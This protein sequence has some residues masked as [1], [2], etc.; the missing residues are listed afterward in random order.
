MPPIDPNTLP[1]LT[2]KQMSFE[3]A[4]KFGLSITTQSNDDGIITIRGLTR[5]G[6]FL[7]SHTTVSD[8]DRHFQRFA[9]PDFPI[10]IVAINDDATLNHG[11]TF[12][13]IH[14]EINDNSMLQLCSGFIDSMTSISYPA[15]QKQDRIPGRGHI[16]EVVGANPAAGAEVSVTVP[17]GAIWLIHAFTVTFVADANPANRRVNIL[18]T[19][20]NGQEVNTVTNINQV[21]GATKKYNVANYGAFVDSDQLDRLPSQLPSNL[22]LIAG[23]TIT[24]STESI[25]AGDDFG[26]PI[27][28]LEEFFTNNG[29]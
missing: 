6:P 4:T 10:C 1:F 14:L 8:R 25:Q 27:I 22:Y 2:R 3:H 24:T 7:F 16:R 12:A 19:N 17:N 13:S 29:L 5:E 9:V 18:F 28:L 20:P 23:G 21:A 11:Q 15:L 26:A